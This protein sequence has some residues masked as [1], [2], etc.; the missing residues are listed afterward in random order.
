[1]P[2]HAAIDIGTNAVLLLI[3]DISKQGLTPLHLETRI[4]RLGQQ[5]H[6]TGELTPSAIDQVTTIL[7]DYQRIIQNFGAEPVLVTGTSAAR[8]AKNQSKLVEAVRKTTGWQLRILSG[9]EE[10]RLTFEGG[11]LGLTPDTSH[12]LLVDIGGGSTELV[13]GIPS[14]PSI[15]ASISL[16]LGAV[17]LLEKFITAAPTP[18]REYHALQQAIRAELEMV[19]QPPIPPVTLAGVA[20]TVTTLAAIH[21]GLAE[22]IPGQLHNQRLSR[23]DIHRING[24]LRQQSLSERLQT[25]GLHL[26]REDVIIVGATILETIMEMFGFKTITISEYGLRYGV[27]WDY[28][29][30]TEHR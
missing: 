6:L 24:Q 27:L 7:Q 13:W 26:G 25:P 3:A 30:Q 18:E 2:V 14:P 28:I 11:V 1:M 9:E 15:Y 23:H 16:N 22:E 12:I 20:G 5:V 4:A 19:P 21:F 8:D 17:R 29:S 10:A